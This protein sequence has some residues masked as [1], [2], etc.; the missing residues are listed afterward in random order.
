MRPEH[1][2]GR[3]RIMTQKVKLIFETGR[4]VAEDAINRA[5]Q[6]LEFEGYAITQIINI[7]HSERPLDDVWK[8]EVFGAKEKEQLIEKPVTKVVDDRGRPLN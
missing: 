1:Q 3:P 5:I 2:M 8:V 4:Q 6:D 7:S